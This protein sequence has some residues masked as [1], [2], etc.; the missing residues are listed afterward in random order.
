MPMQSLK[1][2]TRKKA[3]AAPQEGMNLYVAEQR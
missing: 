2:T 3:A 1:Q